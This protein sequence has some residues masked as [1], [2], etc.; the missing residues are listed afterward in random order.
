MK[1]SV[2]SAATS[3]SSG[4]GGSHSH[5]LRRDFVLNLETLL[6]REVDATTSSYTAANAGGVKNNNHQQQQQQKVTMEMD[7]QSQACRRRHVDATVDDFGV[8]AIGETGQGAERDCGGDNSGSSSGRQVL[9]SSDRHFLRTYPLRVIDQLR[10]C[11]FETTPSLD[12][13]SCF[14]TMRMYGLECIHC[15]KVRK[16]S[17]NSTSVVIRQ[18]KRGFRK[19]PKNTNDVV[20]ALLDFRS[21]LNV[22]S[23]VSSDLVSYLNWM[24]QWC[25]FPKVVKS[26]AI[27]ISRRL[28]G[29]RK[30][31]KALAPPPP[32]PMLL[33]PSL[34]SPQKNMN[35][36][37]KALVE[38]PGIVLLKKSKRSA[39]GRSH[40][41]L[42]NINSL[43]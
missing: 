37:R 14:K 32:P 26:V 6:Q 42:E 3:S 20:R 31:G 38:N 4:N 21:H 11:Y 41:V 30:R 5:S 10:V 15:N 13:P 8:S 40:S 29:L 2:A 39:R 12:A 23:S 7:I 43:D 17:S 1:P 18:K 16:S 36:K 35:M 9:L 27:P 25:R 28:D 24:E 33:L 34:P 19:Y 22:C